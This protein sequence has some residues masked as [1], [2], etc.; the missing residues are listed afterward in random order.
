MRTPFKFLTLLAALV[1][2]AV[3]VAAC[4]GGSSSTSGESTS[5]SNEGASSEAGGSSSGGKIDPGQR[6]IGVLPSTLQSEHL[7]Q[8]IEEL[9]AAVKP[10]GW[11]IVVADGQANPQVMEQDMQKL[12]QQ[13]VDAILTMALGGEEIQRGLEAAKEANIPVLSLITEPTPPEVSSFAGTYADS[14]VGLG[15]LGGEYIIK[16]RGEIPVIGEELTQNYGGQAFIDGMQKV[17]KKENF[18][19]EQLKDTEL[20][21]LTNSMTQN[22]ETML[23]SAPKGPLTVV[24]FSDFG[25]PIFQPILEKTGREAETAVMTRYEDPASIKVAKNGLEVLFVTTEAYKHIFKAIEGLIAYWTEEAPLETEIENPGGK[26][27]VVSE[28]PKG[29]EQFF[30]FPEALKK[31]EEEWAS[32]YEMAG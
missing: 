1:A 5:S 6:T 30:D 20:A 25:A 14:S 7:A 16:E 2:L 11:K 8:R 17:F 28:L 4:G 27:R 22:L 13:H 31:Q 3:G 19:F 24:E 12:I 15:E 26:V 29:S 18:E 9:E 10:F 32:K 21:N 23:Q